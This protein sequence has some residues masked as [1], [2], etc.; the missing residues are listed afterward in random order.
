[1]KTNTSIILSLCILFSMACNEKKNTENEKQQTAANTYKEGEERGYIVK[2]GEMAP[3][4]EMELLSGDRIKLSDL[5]GK[6]VMLQFTAS[7]CGVCLKEMPHIESDIWQQYKDKDFALFGI[8][9]DEPVEKAQL[10]IDKTN[11]TYPIALDPGAEIFK[12]YA[13]PKSGV[14]RNVL[15]DRDGRIVFLTRLFN[16]EEFSEL[17]KKIASLF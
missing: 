14:T 9:K 5:K 11:I 4:F 15:I 3:D 10:L 8:D 7:W 6:V 12:L 13:H 2:V 16:E 1:M 17:K